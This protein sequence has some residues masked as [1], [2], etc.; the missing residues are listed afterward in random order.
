MELVRSKVGFP[1][2]FAFEEFHPLQRAY[3]SLPASDRRTWTSKEDLE[4]EARGVVGG[5]RIL[6]HISAD[7]AAEWANW[8][9]GELYVVGWYKTYLFCL[10]GGTVAGPDK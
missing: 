8:N 3:D 6:G 10:R 5:G 2:R 9:R 7:V 4:L 1:P